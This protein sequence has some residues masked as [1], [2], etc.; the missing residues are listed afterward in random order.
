MKSEIPSCES[1]APNTRRV[2][3][4]L[5]YT[6]D[7]ERA[8]GLVRRGEFKPAQNGSLVLTNTHSQRTTQDD[9]AYEHENDDCE[10]NK[11]GEGAQE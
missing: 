11:L 9:R 3:E 2:K 1:T 8:R 6:R 10:E 4:L 5:I 7:H